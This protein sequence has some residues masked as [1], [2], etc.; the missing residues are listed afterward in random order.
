MIQSDSEPG[1][2]GA[3]IPA[4]DN[5]DDGEILLATSSEEDGCVEPP[6]KK[7]AYSKGRTEGDKLHFLQQPVCRFAHMRLY[8]IGSSALQNMR[9]GDP[10]FTMHS[11]RLQEPKHPSLGV[12]MVR[13]SVNQRWPSIMSFFWLLWI[14]CAEVLPVKFTMPGNRDGGFYE[15]TMSADPEFQE[16]YVQNFLGCLE[17]NYD[18]NPV[19][20]HPCSR[21]FLL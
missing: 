3:I 7:R 2:T 6:V 9:R 4:S 11:G 21:T 8:S 14:S 19:T 15:S 12:S 17:R 16:R 5:D 1:D 10:A 20:H 18:V 13:S